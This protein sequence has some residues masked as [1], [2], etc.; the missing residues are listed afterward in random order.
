M[1]EVKQ[2]KTF[3]INSWVKVKLTDHGIAIEKENHQKLKEFYERR[4]V[5]YGVD[6]VPE[7]DEHGYTAYQLWELFERFGEHMGLGKRLPFETDIL[8]I[9][10]RGLGDTVTEE[11]AYGNDCPNGS[12]DV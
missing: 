1:C 10:A 2:L 5:S 9:E 8:L 6:E 4:G 7:T 11:Q 12:C 3:N